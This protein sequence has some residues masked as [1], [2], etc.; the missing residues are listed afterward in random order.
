[1]EKVL[2]KQKKNQEAKRNIGTVKSGDSNGSLHGKGH[3]S[4]PQGRNGN[5]GKDQFSSSLGKSN[6]GNINQ[7]VIK[8]EEN[9]HIEQESDG[10]RGGKLDKDIRGFLKD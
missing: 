10:G 2:A 4:K 5:A 1:L 8:E 9:E 6:Q 7:A 3:H